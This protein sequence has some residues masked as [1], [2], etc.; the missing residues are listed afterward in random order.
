MWKSTNLSLREDSEQ[1]ISR[2]VG[3]APQY[4]EQQRIRSVNSIRLD[5]HGH[6]G[7]GR[8]TDSTDPHS[9]ANSPG[10]QDESGDDHEGEEDAE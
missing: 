9:R 6:D 10:M 1:E 8:S 3:G 4:Y 7:L 5:K 2:D